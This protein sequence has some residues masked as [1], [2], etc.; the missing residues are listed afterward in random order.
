M[1]QS[2][3]NPFLCK[4]RMHILDGDQIQAIHL[5][6]LEI[7]DTIGM[8]V[9][10]P[11]G[12]R[13]LRNAGCII[14]DGNVALIPPALVDE[15]IRSAPSG[16][17]VYNRRG[18]Q[19]MRLEGRNTYFG[20]GT[21][22]LRTV[23]LE[24]GNTRLSLLQDVRNA[25]RVADACE[26]VDFI[27]SFALPSDVPT[28]IMYL[29]CVRVMLENSTKPIF[30]TAAGKED[31]A[32]IIEMCEA[33]M[34]GEKA[35]RDTPIYIHYS[36]PTPPL[37][38]SYGAINKLFLCAEKGVPICYPPGAVM[39]G[40][41]PV[42]LAGAIV[43]VNAEALSGVV[44]HQLRKKGAP[45]ISGF[46]ALPMDMRT[47]TFSYASPELRLTNSVMADLYEHYGLPHWST[48]GSDAHCLDEQASMEHALCT[49]TSALDGANLIHDI[50][51][52]GQGLLG[53]PAAIVMSDEIIS[54]VKRYME[55][56][57]ISR[58]KIGVDVIRKVGPGGNF[59]LEDHTVQ[60]FRKELWRPKQL[61][62]ENP[63]NWLAKGAQRYGDV[64]REKALHILRTH[65]PEPL[66]AAVSQRLSQISATASRALADFEFK[67]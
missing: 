10:H 30:N 12:I 22:L 67:A 48:V 24:T 17:S 13:L 61:N 18:E 47:T 21:D 37:T 9:L 4:P 1:P 11:E 63:D 15:C 14:K 41:S 38:H 3:L 8:R 51:Y 27:A 45:I 44:L 29:E 26:N 33:V 64:V 25:A 55:G 32:Y 59:F 62:R 56:F 28:N 23:D 35:L 6:T 5:A 2:E 49:L 58:E 50:G 20:M 31:L 65:Q 16:I 53:N 66:P 43:Q 39:G 19:A 34:G 40:S 52:L 60:N 46:G 57:E 42:T 54:Y 36:E 7:L